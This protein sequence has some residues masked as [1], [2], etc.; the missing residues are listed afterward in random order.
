ME[1]EGI[2]Y[3]VKEILIHV[4]QS[5]ANSQFCD[6]L[7]FLSCCIRDILISALTHIM[8]LVSSYTFWKSQKSPDVLVFSRVIKMGQSYEMS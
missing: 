6:F 5:S 7:I 1:T 8:L 2:R 4:S 3:P